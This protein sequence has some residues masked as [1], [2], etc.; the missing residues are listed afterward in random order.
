MQVTGGKQS[1]TGKIRTAKAEQIVGTYQAKVGKKMPGNQKGTAKVEK[2]AKPR[3]K[4]RG[5][6]SQRV[7]ESGKAKGRAKIIGFGILGLFLGLFSIHSKGPIHQR[8][9]AVYWHRERRQR[10]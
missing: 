2:V 4:G 3:P 7:K 8:R 1:H 10:R 6:A 5:K 9:V